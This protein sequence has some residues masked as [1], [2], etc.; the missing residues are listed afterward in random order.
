MEVHSHIHNHPRKPL[1]EYVYE[2]FMLF[3]AVTAGFYADNL[4]EKYVEREKEHQYM[5]AMVADLK[6]DLQQMDKAM[7]DLKTFKP[8]L[9]SLA[10]TCYIK[11][12]NDSVLRVLYDL[13][14]R[15]LRLIPITF[16]DRTSSQLK[17]SGNLRLIRNKQ[18]TDSLLNYWQGIDYF[19][20]VS[21]LNENFRRKARELSFRIFDYGVYD[22]DLGFARN[23]LKVSNPRLNNSDRALLSE[24]V[25]FV[26]A[27]RSTQSIYYYPP[28]QRLHDQAANLKELIMKAYEFE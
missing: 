2:F 19:N 9:D 8:G 26:W 12:M 25:N 22:N 5:Q 14:L 3:I 20:Y 13:N 21:P 11:E 16:S 15:Y 6:Q 7:V 17:N 28:I 24:Y 18:V 27:Y 23:N 10:R 4:R 1:R